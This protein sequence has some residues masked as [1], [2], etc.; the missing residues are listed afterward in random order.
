MS[1]FDVDSGALRRVG[2]P[3]ARHHQLVGSLALLTTRR[4]VRSPD[5]SMQD[6][7]EIKHAH[8]FTASGQ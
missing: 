6:R 8:N 7:V 1:Y 2:H 4:E 3:A 5:S